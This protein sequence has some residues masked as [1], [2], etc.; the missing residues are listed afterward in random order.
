MGVTRRLPEATGSPA[1]LPHPGGTAAAALVP[2]TGVFT[3]PLAEG[4][5]LG[6]LAAVHPTSSSF[7]FV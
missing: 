3:W 1:T 5:W 2:P 7:S 6:L 4:G